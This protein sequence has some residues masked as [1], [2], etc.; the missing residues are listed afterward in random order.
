MCE[1]VCVRER[2]RE[3][4]GERERKTENCFNAQS[5]VMVT[6][7]RNKSGFADNTQLQKSAN[8]IEMINLT[9]YQFKLYNNKTEAILVFSVFFF[10]SSSS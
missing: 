5:T 3:R 4:G 6:S 9:E 8:F 7:G 2:V 10:F 1:C